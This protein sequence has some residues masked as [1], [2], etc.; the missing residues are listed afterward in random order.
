MS[1]LAV[2]VASPSTTAEISGAPASLRVSGTGGTVP[3]VQIVSG[4]VVN[5]SLRVNQNTASDFTIYQDSTERFLFASGGDLTF[6][7]GN[8]IQGT[9]SKG[10]DFAANTGAAGVTSKLLNW[11]EEGT[12]TPTLVGY[13]TAG[14]YTLTTTTAKYIRVGKLVT[15]SFYATITTN[16]AGSG[17]ARFG[18]L[19][20]P[21]ANA[22]IMV[23]SVATEYIAIASTIKTLVPSWWTSSSDSTF[24]LAGLRDN[25]TLLD[26]TCADLGAS[27]KVSVTLTYITD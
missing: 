5:W 7:T 20:F 27:A 23:G 3:Q 13:T 16:S 6:K 17:T 12:W 1:T 4:G 25:T 8:L 10:V 18:G 24:Y 11:Y 15:A 2:G 21:K 22:S 19:P 14:S 26:I 9:A